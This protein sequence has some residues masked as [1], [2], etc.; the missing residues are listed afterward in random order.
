M[1]VKLNMY[2]Y[3]TGLISFSILLSLFISA[4]DMYDHYKHHAR[5]YKKAQ[6]YLKSDVCTNPFMIR[7]MQG[8]TKCSYYER[9]M[10][11]TPLMAAIFDTAE[12]LHICGRGY[13]S[14]LGHNITNSL[15]QILATLAIL[16]VILLW[17][18]GIQ[19]RRNQQ[20]HQQQYWSLPIR[21][22]PKK[23]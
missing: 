15:P 12:D 19:F 9:V 8:D 1:C 23:D 20:Q 7:D 3:V 6:I 16:A 21:T 14:L 17:A 2:H 5:Q 10:D 4:G 18:S 13:C 11:K 22:R